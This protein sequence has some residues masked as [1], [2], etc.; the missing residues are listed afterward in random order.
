[1][2][3]L[4]KCTTAALAVSALTLALLG[5]Q[6]QEGPAETAGKKIDKAAQ[7]SRRAN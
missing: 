2:V 7:K 1:M 4:K 6:K 3:E 5:C